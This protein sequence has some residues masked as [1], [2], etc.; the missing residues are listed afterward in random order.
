MVSNDCFGCSRQIMTRAL[1]M[2]D[3]ASQLALKWARQGP[4]TPIMVTHDF[5]RTT[6]DTIALC[7]MGCRFNSFY[8][9]QIHPF[10][11]AMINL[12]RTSGERSRRAP[13]IRNMPSKSNKKYW[14]DITFMR[15]MSQKMVDER[16]NHPV[17]KS[18]LLNGL[19]LGRD[20]QTGQ[21]LSDESIVDNMITFLIAGTGTSP[22]IWNATDGLQ[23][24]KPH[25]AS[26]LS[27]SISFS[28]TP[29]STEKHKKKSTQSSGVVRFVR[30]TYHTC[31]TSRPLF[32]KHFASG[33]H[34]LISR[35]APIQPT[36]KKTQSP[37]EMGSMSSAKMNRSLPF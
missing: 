37:S 22:L 15:E 3:I 9:D 34:R 28:K 20:P 32:A 29:R 12:L 5:T 19:I 1:D 16:R 11:V 17:D 8:T 10:V 30:T 24:M 18:D 35:L 27:F 7:A 14:E 25:Q 4:R 33:P 36:T 13:W 21:G 23:V 6:L 31:H 26:F 2:Y